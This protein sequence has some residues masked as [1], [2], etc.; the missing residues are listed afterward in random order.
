M[1]DALLLFDGFHIEGGLGSAAFY[2]VFGLLFVF[3]GIVLLVGILSLIGL[4]MKKTGARKNTKSKASPPAETQ[5][6]PEIEAGI[7]P[8]VVAAITAAIAVYTEG[9]MAKCDFVIRRIKR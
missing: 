7:P 2:A 9:E 1:K 3:A 4:I 6:L 8:E 5:P